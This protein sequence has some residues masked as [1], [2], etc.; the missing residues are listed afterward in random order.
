MENEKI[1][2]S[3]LSGALQIIVVLSWVMVALSVLNV[4]LA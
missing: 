3:N 1:K 4:M 2:F